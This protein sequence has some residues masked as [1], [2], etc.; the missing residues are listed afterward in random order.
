MEPAGGGDRMSTTSAYSVSQDPRNIRATPKAPLPRVASLYLACVFAVTVAATAPFFQNLAAGKPVT[1]WTAFVVLGIGAAISQIFVVRAGPN[2]SYHTS[3]LFLVAAALLLPPELIVLIGI[4]QNVPEWLKERYTWYIQSFNICNYTLS[5]LAAWGAFRLICPEG[6]FESS[7]AAFAIG[8]LAACVAFV[9]TN[10]LLLST[11]LVL[12]RGHSFR[13]VGLFS[14]ESLSTNLVLTALGVVLAAFWQS[15]P[16]MIPFAIAP[17]LVVHRSLSVPQLQAEA[18][19]DPKTGLYNAR[20]FANVL[21]EEL[22]RAARFERL[23]S[24]IMADLDL[25]RDIN[26]SYG[27]L[28]GDAVLKGIAEVFR[29]ELRHYD[30]PARF[31]GEEFSILLPE[32][33]PEQALEIAARSPTGRSTSRPRASPS[34]PP[35][36]SAWPASRRTARTPTSSSTRPTSPSTARSCRAATASSAPA[37]SCCSCPP[38]ARRG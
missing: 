16:W 22:G 36:R 32:T 25:L 33:S 4:V 8:G 24:L 20:H 28:A 7:P 9:A 37:P 6:V 18:R 30:V 29:A 5:T 35:S 21:S 19:V 3:V 13:A 2:R 11:A 34:A 26:N 14:F 17:L 38:S 15:N 10:H 23:L 12:A 1:E 31:G 27:H